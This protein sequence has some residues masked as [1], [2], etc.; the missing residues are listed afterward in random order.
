MA[1]TI[2]LVVLGIA[3]RLAPHAPGAV[4]LGAIALFSGARLPRSRAAAVPILVLALSDVF[5]GWDAPHVAV[6]AAV[7]GTLAAAA[8]AGRRL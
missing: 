4:P 3:L 1:L 6:R 5:L 2:F 8:I 7:Y